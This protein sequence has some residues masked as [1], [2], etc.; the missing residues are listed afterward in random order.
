MYKIY[1]NYDGDME[2]LGSGTLKECK[3]L[4]KE[5]IEDTDGECYLII[6]DQ[7]GERSLI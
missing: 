7:N 4:A 2:L 3:R 6:E 1:D 5:R